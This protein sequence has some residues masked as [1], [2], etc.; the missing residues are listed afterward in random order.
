MGK[1]PENKSPLEDYFFSYLGPI[2]IAGVKGDETSGTATSKDPARGWS[3][4][5]SGTPREISEAPRSQYSILP[6]FRRRL[7]DARWLNDYTV[8]YRRM[9]VSQRVATR[10]WKMTE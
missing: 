8:A 4:D 6:Q 10:Y 9:T 3:D 2:G 7:Y 1:E 5:V